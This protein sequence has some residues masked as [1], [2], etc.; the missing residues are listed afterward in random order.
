MT[1]MI[2]QLFLSV[3]NST[4]MGKLQRRYEYKKTAITET[5]TRAKTGKKKGQIIATE[6]HFAEGQ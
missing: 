1:V 4:A 3:V 2:I 5:N 6:S